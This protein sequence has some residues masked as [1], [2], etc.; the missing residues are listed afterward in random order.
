MLSGCAG[1]KPNASRL[2]GAPELLQKCHDGDFLVEMIDAL[3][4]AEGLTDLW[5]IEF[6]G[7]AQKCNINSQ[8][9]QEWAK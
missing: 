2:S 6:A 8:G 1:V 9:L 5:L 7:E 4:G 3:D